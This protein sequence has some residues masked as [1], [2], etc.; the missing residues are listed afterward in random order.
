MQTIRPA[1]RT[2]LCSIR[3]SLEGPAGRGNGRFG[4]GTRPF[5]GNC[6]RG[7]KC[8]WKPQPRVKRADGIETRNKAQAKRAPITARGRSRIG[9]RRVL[10]PWLSAVS[11]G[12][13][14]FQ[15]ARR[16]AQIIQLRLQL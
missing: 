16:T 9:E 15:I 13:S 10:L 6:G 5:V 2:I 12:Q 7:V 4:A 3:E 1:L 14:V 8:P 11:D